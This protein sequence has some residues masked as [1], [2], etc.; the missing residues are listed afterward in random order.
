M[1]VCV[2][3]WRWWHLP[4][5]VIKSCNFV[6]YWNA[7]RGNT[8]FYVLPQS[9]AVRAS[10]GP[11]RST[12]PKALHT[13]RMRRWSSW[14]TRTNSHAAQR[15]ELLLTEYFL[16][17]TASVVHTWHWR[18]NTRQQ[19]DEVYAVG[20]RF[21]TSRSAILQTATCHEIHYHTERQT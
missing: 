20:S 15:Q 4:S 7:F 14:L 16:V 5:K 13:S 11:H 3:W 19:L 8:K 1:T 18:T 10:W 21:R 2:W 12:A 6:T 17:T 9:V